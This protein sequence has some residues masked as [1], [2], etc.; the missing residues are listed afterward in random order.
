MEGEKTVELHFSAE[1]SGLY[2]MMERYCAANRI[3]LESYIKD[4]IKRDLA[5]GHFA[6][7]KKPRDGEN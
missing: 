1:E 4:Q 7:K 2:A 5:W 3:G 6:G